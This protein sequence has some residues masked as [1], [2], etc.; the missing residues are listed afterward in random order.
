M[1]CNSIFF[2]GLPGKKAFVTTANVPSS[3]RIRDGD[4]EEDVFIVLF[5]ASTNDPFEGTRERRSFD[6]KSDLKRPG[7]RFTFSTFSNKINIMQCNN[8]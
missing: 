4:N 1:W 7:F 8:N 6:V 3:R 2:N 5:T